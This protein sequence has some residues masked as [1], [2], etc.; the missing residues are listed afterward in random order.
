MLFRSRGIDDAVEMA[1]L[2]AT[3]APITGANKPGAPLVLPCSTGVIGR[4]LP[5]EKIRAGIAALAPTV[6]RGNAADAATAT[7][8]MT[9]DLVPKS[10]HR[11]VKLNGKTITL[12]GIAKG[13]G[14]IQPNLAT[15][16]G[17]ITT[18]A[19]IHPKALKAALKAA[20]TVSFNRLSVDMDTSTSD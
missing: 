19:A 5:M 12:A 16:F 1:K 3:H 18:D 17:F 8:I 20:V 10:A 14:M 4:Y 13:S 7:A 6:S 15:M 11:T 2:V 9:T